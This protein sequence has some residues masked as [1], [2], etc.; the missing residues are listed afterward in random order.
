MFL[1]T[2]RQ[3]IV[4]FVLFVVFAILLVSHNKRYEFWF[5]RAFLILFVILA[6]GTAR[7]V[8]RM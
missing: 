5:E 3:V 1:W 7:Y 4:F 2:Y 6:I 8:L